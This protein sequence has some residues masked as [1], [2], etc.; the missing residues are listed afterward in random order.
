MQKVYQLTSPLTFL[1]N[2]FY[3]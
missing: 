3:I 1:V 2:F